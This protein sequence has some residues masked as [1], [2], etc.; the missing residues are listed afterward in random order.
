MKLIIN[1]TT[2]SGTGVTQV[3]VSFIYECIAFTENSYHIFLSKTVSK[4]INIKDFPGNFKFYQFENH[5][6]YGLKGWDTRKKLRKLESVINPDI[7]FS[8]FGPACWTPKSKHVT[9]FANSYYVYPESP[10]FK[11]IS[12]KNWIRINLMKI[13]HRFFLKRNGAYFICE[14]EDMSRRLVSFLGT[15]N[16]N[17]FTVSNTFNKYFEKT[18]LA[19]QK[20]LLPKPAPEEFRLLSLASFDIHKNLT[21]INDISAK[22]EA[23]KREK[24]IKFIL[25]ID[26]LK[27]DK[28]FSEVAKRHI[29]NLGRIDVK[30]CPQLYSECNALFLPT[31]IESFS[32]NYPEAMKM[33]IPILTSHYTFAKSVCDNAALYFDPLDADDIVK[34]IMQIINDK[35]LSNLLVE[36]GRQRLRV[37]GNAQKRAERYFEVFKS[38]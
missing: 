24:D 12:F 33:E 7:V 11:K 17:V 2:L 26:P 22:L 31:L 9:G 10:F 13:A 20:K 25:T 1:T 6:L 30:D 19:S 4:E 28:N 29:I 27:L 3:A 14:T 38:I 36:N 21:I 23:S 37:F 35:A 8:V 18:N 5:P 34:K 32:A 15:K 16:S